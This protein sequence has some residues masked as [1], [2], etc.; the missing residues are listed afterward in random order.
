MADNRLSLHLGK[1]ESIIFGT[2]RM[3]K[4]VVDFS[5]TCGE[6]PVTR[7]NTV[8][9]LGV[10]LDEKLSGEAHALKVIG[11]ISSRLSFLYRQSSLLDVSTKK[12]LCIAL[13]Q[14]LF[15]YCST[16]WHEGLTVR[17]KSRFDVLQRK[18]VRLIYGLHPQCHVGLQDYKRLGWLTVKDRVS[19]F[20]LV[21]VFRISRGMAP[22]YLSNG[23]TNVRQVHSYNTRGSVSDYHISDVSSS[24]LVRDSFGFRGRMEWNSLPRDLK[25]IS[26]LNAFKK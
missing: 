11:N 14:P 7:V 16:A 24:S 2:S 6:S 4:K 1:T 12:T 5:V 13:I 25:Q 15:D 21:H 23:F 17:T 22:A 18:M 20:R 3:L 10:I 9:Y 26:S 8:K 19:F